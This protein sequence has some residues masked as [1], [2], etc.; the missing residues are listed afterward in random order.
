MWRY[1]WAV[2]ALALIGGCEANHEHLLKQGY[3][4]ALP[5]PLL[6]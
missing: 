2:L 5:P 1:G 4:P 3:P 6:H